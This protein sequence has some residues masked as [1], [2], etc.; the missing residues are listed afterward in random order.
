M[1]IRKH[2]KISPLVYATSSLKPGT[3]LQTHVCQLNQSPW[4]VMKF[5]PP[6]TP[7]PP[8]PQVDG[9][10]ACAVNGSL[11]DRLSVTERD[12]REYS[13]DIPAEEP[14]PPPPAVP[15]EEKIIFCC[16][17]DGK[18][19]QCKKE[20]A[21]GNSLCHHHL[22][23][24]KSYSNGYHYMAKKPEKMSAEARRP[25]RTKKAS[26]SSNPYEFYYYSGFGPRWGKKRGEAYN[27]TNTAATDS[28]NN[29][30]SLSKNVE[31]EDEMG[32]DESHF[33]EYEE[34]EEI[35]NRDNHIGKKRVRKPIKA[36]SLKSLM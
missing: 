20:A 1:R 24:A 2:A 3:H 36:R 15:A 27:N 17:T 18:S 35:N 7:P 12:Q 21:K 10:G 13:D 19:W 22:S 31:R 4:D 9:D 11:R 16:K 23:Q 30:G 6:S 5:S 14:Q 33:D 8:P 29:N 28:N 25:A 32:D 34:E 26:T